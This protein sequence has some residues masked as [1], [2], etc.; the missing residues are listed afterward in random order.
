MDDLTLNAFCYFNGG[1]AVRF[2]G[3]WMAGSQN[4]GLSWPCAMAGNFGFRGEIG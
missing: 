4:G 1:G 3:R 2:P